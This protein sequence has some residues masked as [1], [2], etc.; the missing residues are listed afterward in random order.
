MTDRAEFIAGLRKLA[1]LLDERDD[2]PLPYEG[3]SAHL[4]FFLHGDNQAERLA[5]FVRLMDG[6][7]DKVPSYDYFGVDGSLFGIKVSVNADRDA[8]CERVVVGTETVEVPD[9]DALAAVPTIVE[10]RELV[11]WRCRPV[12]AASGREAAA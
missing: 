3:T 8:V 6:K 5:D 9:P 12:L 4:L 11:E 1:D 10:E 7:K 2:F